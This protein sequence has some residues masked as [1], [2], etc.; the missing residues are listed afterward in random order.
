VRADGGPLDIDAA[1]SAIAATDREIVGLIA[2]RLDLA[3][4][5]GAAKEARGLPVC[6]PAREA[7]VLRDAAAAAREQGLDAEVVR[8]VFWCIIGLCR[9]A[10]VGTADV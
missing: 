4:A 2:R 7:A 3:Q 10:Q 1:R 8:Q 9:D 5:V 6:D